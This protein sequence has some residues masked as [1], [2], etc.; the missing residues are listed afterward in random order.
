MPTY[1]YRVL[2]KL[3]RKTE[4]LIDL[5]F[6]SDSRPDITT[7]DDGRKAEFDFGATVAGVNTTPAGA[8]PRLSNALGVNRKQVE[9]FNKKYPHHG[10]QKD[11]RL[12]IESPGHL[13]Q[14]LK[15]RPGFGDFN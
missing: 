4:E 1:T 14:I 8:W 15:D 13:K 12:K 6:P 7:L 9:A 10:Y 11:G 2:D 3:G 5:I